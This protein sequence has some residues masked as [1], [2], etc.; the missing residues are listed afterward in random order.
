MSNLYKIPFGASG[1]IVVA[2]IVVA[3][4]ILDRTA[5]DTWALNTSL[6]TSRFLPIYSA[7]TI[8]SLIIQFFLLILS[9]RMYLKIKRPYA[10]VSK[11]LQYVYLVS[12]IIVISLIATVVAEQIAAYGYHT[13]LLKLIVGVSL[14][15]SVIMLVFLALTFIK[16]YLSTK[17]KMITLYSLAMLALCAQLLSAFFY[18]EVALDGIT[19][20]FITQQRNPWQS[21]FN[22]N[23]LGLTS[24]IYEYSKV[25]SFATV[26]VASVLLTKQYSNRSKARYSSIVIIPVIYFLIQYLLMLLTEN[27]VLSSLFVSE[28]LLYSYAYN[29]LFNTGNVG[30]G[31]LFGISFFIVSRSL[32]HVDL[33]YYIAICG[34]GIMILF[35]SGVSTLLLKAPFPLWALLSISFTSP[36]SFLI[37]MGLDSAIYHIARDRTVRMYLHDYQNKFRLFYSLGSAESWAMVERNV[38]KISN[39]ISNNIEVETMY[40]PTEEEDDIKKYVSDV[41]AE[42]KK[43]NDADHWESNDKPQ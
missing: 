18:I 34:A 1:I 30:T 7:V 22:S 33:K 17:N 40:R 8:A 31:I 2:A 20:D 6:E 5:G 32:A 28:S 36:A 15:V 41:I 16:S 42:M 21:S 26:W 12:Q 4:Q 37:L 10:Q 9:S 11:C 39:R 29:F 13:I 27:G 23:L 35:S 38:K 24:S 43:S 14:V 3:L 25:F 19:D